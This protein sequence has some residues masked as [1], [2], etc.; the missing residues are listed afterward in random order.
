[1]R[2]FEPN[3]TLMAI[4]YRYDDYANRLITRCEGPITYAEVMEHF[5]Q[6][7]RDSRLKQHCDVLLDLTFLVSMPTAQQ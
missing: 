1:M 6:L 5:R 4:T 3:A 7:T 2:R